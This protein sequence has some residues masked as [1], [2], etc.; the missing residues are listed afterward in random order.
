[1]PTISPLENLH[2]QQS[3]IKDR[4]RAVGYR[5]ANGGAKMMKIV[6]AEVA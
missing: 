4:I 6:V 1:M 3:L 5:E 2:R